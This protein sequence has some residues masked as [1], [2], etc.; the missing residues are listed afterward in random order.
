MEV[1][2]TRI[3]A[4]LERYNFSLKKSDVGEREGMNEDISITTPNITK[5]PL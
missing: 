4:L 2:F 3:D 5:D 1:I